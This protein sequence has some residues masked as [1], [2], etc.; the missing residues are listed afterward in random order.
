[1]T[2]TNQKQDGIEERAIELAQMFH[3]TYERLAPQFGYETRDDTKVFDPESPN[4]RLMIAVVGELLDFELLTR[5]KIQQLVHYRN[6]TATLTAENSRLRE[7]LRAIEAKALCFPDNY[8]NK[9]AIKLAA[10]EYKS[11]VRKIAA[12]A[13]LSEE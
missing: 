3:N 7:S 6:E 4:G 5:A 13:L 8:N 2:N 10:L 1:M 12:K 9:A 11:T